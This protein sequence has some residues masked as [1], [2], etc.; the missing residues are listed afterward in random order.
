MSMSSL[1]I[2]TRRG[3]TEGYIHSPH[4]RHLFKV[5]CRDDPYVGFL[6]LF[7]PW[8]LPYAHTARV[9]PPTNSNPSS[10]TIQGPPPPLVE[11]TLYFSHINQFNPIP[12][13]EKPLEV[14]QITPPDVHIYNLNNPP[15]PSVAKFF[16]LN[17]LQNNNFEISDI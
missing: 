9:T 2:L 8:K 16:T 15:A 14:H 10:H 1:H 13:Q 6:L 17:L 5:L 7:S 4:H 3:G 11:P 12:P